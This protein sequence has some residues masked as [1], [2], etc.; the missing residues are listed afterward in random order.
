M[1]LE[2]TIGESICVRMDDEDVS[3]TGLVPEQFEEYLVRMRRQAVQCYMDIPATSM[4]APGDDN[5]EA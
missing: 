3:I 2:V 4:V 5:D 1:M